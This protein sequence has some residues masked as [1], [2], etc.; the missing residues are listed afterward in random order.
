MRT[1]ARV[2]L[3]V[4]GTKMPDGSW[5][6]IM[7]CCN[8]KGSRQRLPGDRELLPDEFET[9]RNYT[10]HAVDAGAVDKVTCLKC[11]PKKGTTT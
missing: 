3:I 9:W 7:T 10:F 2:H 4:G 11:K 6:Q 8:R 5:D 1:L